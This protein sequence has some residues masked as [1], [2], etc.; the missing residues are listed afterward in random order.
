MKN[1]RKPILTEDYN[2]DLPESLIAQN[3]IEPRDSSKLML[4]D[5]NTGKI[6]HSIFSELPN[7]LEPSDLL[8]LNDSKVI[9]ARLKG[10]KMG[11]NA[12]VELLL[13]KKLANG[14]W[15]SLSKPGKRLK[16]DDIINL[17]DGISS[18]EAKII[19]T[20]PDGSK[21]ITLENE[22][23]A[24]TIGELPL[25][26]YIKHNTEPTDRYQTVYSTNLGSVAAPTAGLHFTE[27]LFHNLKERGIKSA[28]TTLHIGLDTFKPIQEDD[29]R[30]HIIHKEFIT[31]DPDSV[32]EIN[33]A[34]SEQR[35]IICVGTTSVRVL[36]FL[37]NRSNSDPVQIEHYSGDNDLFILPGYKFKAI[38]GMI[39]N[40]HLPKSTLLMMISSFSSKSIILNA[41]E[42]AKHHEYR[43]YSYGD[44]MLIL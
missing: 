29:A 2:Y 23:L 9:P 44:A 16:K 24:M 32:N 19:D 3:P 27:N 40:F 34:L 21:I 20:N 14:Y 36:E 5:R 11:T 7:I 22:L 39:T 31:T 8:V 30:N 15:H 4:V 13:L 18:V 6:Q 28:F 43:F 38:S 1:Y 37:A 10:F 42:E 25:P 26:P 12:K 41:Y 35:R 33:K 17:T